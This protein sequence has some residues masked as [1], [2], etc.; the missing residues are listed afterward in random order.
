MNSNNRNWLSFKV[1]DGG[2]DIALLL[3]AIYSEI[4][5]YGI[6]NGQINTNTSIIF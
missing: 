4:A 2:K 5:L 1:I 6:N 3:N